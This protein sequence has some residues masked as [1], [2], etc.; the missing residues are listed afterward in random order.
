MRFLQEI[1]AGVRQKW[2]YRVKYLG[3]E[4]EEA[5]EM[6]GELEGME[7]QGLQFPLD[8]QVNKDDLDA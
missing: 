2:E 6:T 4:E 8:Q 3:E 5:R 7:P 1:S